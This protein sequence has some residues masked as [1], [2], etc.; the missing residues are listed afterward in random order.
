MGE[1]IIELMNTVVENDFCIGCGVCAS[2]KDSPLTMKLDQF[3]KYRPFLNENM[4]QR[5]LEVNALTVCPF[6]SDSKNETEI[7]KELF[8]HNE[9]T[10]FNKYTGY[11]IKNYVGHV[12]EGE[13]RE[14]GSSGGMANWISAQL[15]NKKLVDAVIHVKSVNNSNQVLFK[16]QISHSESELYNG[17]KSR[18]YPIEM[19]QVIKLV[20]ENKGKYAIVGIPC[21][22]KSIRL[23][24]D[25]D[26]EVKERIKYF[27]GLVCGHLKSDMFA[28]SI[29]WELGIEPE[30]LKSIDFRKK[31][32][33]RL[34]YDYGV[35]V[36]GEKNGKDVVLGAPSR[37]LY[38]TNWGHGLFKYNACEFCDDVLAETADV[39]LGDAWLP[40]YSID[41][42]GTNVIVV[43]N[44]VIQKIFEESKED[45]VHIEEISPE[46]VFESQAGGFRHRRDGLSYRLYLKDKNNEWR[47]KKR[48]L[49]SD[50]HSNKR[51]KI[52]AKRA[53]L[54]QESF[55]AYKIA[56]KQKDF[57]AFINH[58]D[59]IIE[60]YNKTVAPSYLS[61]VLRKVRKKVNRLVKQ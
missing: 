37:E 17:A 4:Q 54:S 58:M 24:A 28:K 57:K 18:Y 14:K 12:K 51:K 59:Y 23:L 32:E 47:P 52:Y 48:V 50:K 33:G 15:L 19:S 9:K 46:K 55:K 34:A 1:R 39:T 6:S 3:G 27:I 13:Y 36:E 41:S 42:K 26:K 40:E 44:P 35:E 20:K 10:S 22:I 29:G 38:T 7:G 11:Y 43:R 5:D 8:G 31:L 49:P 60:D 21:F 30:K 25:Q 45:K 56:E 2:L 53:V 16:Y 61:K